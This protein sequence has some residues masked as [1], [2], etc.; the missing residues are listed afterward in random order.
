M[1]A[2]IQQATSA[3][4]PTRRGRTVPPLRRPRI[5][6]A[7][8]TEESCLGWVWRRATPRSWLVSDADAPFARSCLVSVSRRA[9]ALGRTTL[10]R[11]CARDVERRRV[12]CL[13]GREKEKGRAS[14]DLPSLAVDINEMQVDYRGTGSTSQS[15]QVGA[16]WWM[17]RE[18][19]PP[20]LTFRSFCSS[21]PSTRATTGRMRRPRR[22]CIMMTLPSRVRRCLLPSLAQL[23]A[24][25]DPS[26]LQPARAQTSGTVPSTKNPPP[27]SL[28]RT[29]R[30]MMARAT[31]RSDSS[32]IPERMGASLG[33]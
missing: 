6:A 8:T 5:P 11:M 31:R 22:S 3:R 20:K 9:P 15:I 27:S 7:T 18:V 12:S 1:L 23:G 24:R 26:P 33:P 4:S 29:T 28:S 16:E 14:A 32:M 17:Q 2:L 30:R 19:A 25:A 13:R 21:L 10:A